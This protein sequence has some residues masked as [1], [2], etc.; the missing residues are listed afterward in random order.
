MG[1]VSG[2]EVVGVG[3]V[4]LA[5]LESVHCACSF[6]CL[7]LMFLKRCARIKRCEATASL[8]TSTH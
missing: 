3:S 8:I 4:D 7:L 5:F 6:S 2:D 1:I